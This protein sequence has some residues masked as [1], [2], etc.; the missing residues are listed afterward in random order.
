MKINRNIFAAKFLVDRLYRSGVREVCISPGSR[1]TP[2]VFAFESEKRI[3]KHVIIDERAAAFFALGL[4]KSTDKPVALLCT[5]GTAVAEYYPAL[6]EAFQTRVKLVAV[7]ADRPSY[8]RNTGENQCINQENI[9]QNHIKAFFDP[10]LPEVDISYFEAFNSGMSEVCQTLNFRDP[11]PVHINFPCIKPFEPGAFTDDADKDAVNEIRKIKFA[12]TVPK[13]D[14]TLDQDLQNSLLNSVRPLIVVG[15]LKRYDRAAKDIL[16]IAELLNAPVLADITS[17]L[18]YTGRIHKNV[19][20]NYDTLLRAGFPE[21]LAA[22]GLV[23][24]FGGPLNS[25]ILLKYLSGFDCPR[26][27]VNEYGDWTDPS[28]K[29]SAVLKMQPGEIVMFL[30]QNRFEPD[31]EN[32]IYLQNFRELDQ[33]IDYHNNKLPGRKEL[34]EVNTVNIVLESIPDG[35]CLMSGNSLAIRDFDNFSIRLDKKIE[36]YSNRG[37]S[38]IDGVI[39]TAAGLSEG[40]KKRV[41]LV[42]GDLSFLYDLNSLILLNKE[43]VRLTI[44]L[45]NNSGGGIFS[46][47]PVSEYSPEFEKYF[48]TEVRANF[49]KILKGMDIPYREAR[50]AFELRKMLRGESARSGINVIEVKTSSTESKKIRE[51]LRR[52]SG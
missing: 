11:G 42:I 38:G 10:G 9:F 31:P 13:T 47:L 30:K 40:K 2:L 14:T 19:I 28:K 41:F 34:N 35:S 49:R 50:T 51:L 8:L 43:Q 24:H 15:R 3:K 7:T 44:I 1:S 4:S 20:F 25:L 52:H 6:I 39:S 29:S 27:I 37:A 18:R 22:P 33:I 32:K 12:V 16:K 17:K 46:M 21:R 26:F 23:L 48:K 5:S 36:I 45:I